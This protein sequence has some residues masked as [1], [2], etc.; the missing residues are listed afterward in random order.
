LHPLDRQAF[1]G[2]WRD[3]PPSSSAARNGPGPSPWSLWS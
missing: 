1:V 2:S 3:G